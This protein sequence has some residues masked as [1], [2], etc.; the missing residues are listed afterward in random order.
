M[1]VS[2]LQRI[3]V[4]LARHNVRPLQSRADL[5][6]RKANS[7]ILPVQKQARIVSRFSAATD[8]GLG[9]GIRQTDQEIWPQLGSDCATAVWSGSCHRGPRAMFRQL[10]E[11]DT[12]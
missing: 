2:I 7:G 11:G 12:L 10:P 1:Y 4:K 6:T 3:V 5:N 9:A 8:V